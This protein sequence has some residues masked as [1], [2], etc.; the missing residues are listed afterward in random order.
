M[1]LE[2][3]IQTFDIDKLKL[4][5]KDILTSHPLVENQ[6]ALNYRS[7]YEDSCWTDGCGSPYKKDEKSTSI[8]NKSNNMQPRFVDTDFSFINPGL[9]KSEIEKIYLEFQKKFTLGRYRIAVI[10]P[11]TCYGWHFDLEKRIHIPVFTNPGSFIITD[12]GKATHLPSDGG[13][14]MFF[15]NNGYHTAINSSYTE[16]RVHLLINV[17]S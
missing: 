1:Y 10:K 3:L 11:K 12:D 6:I 8:E 16:D 5:V 14:W 7:G 13:C 17:W 9:E 2:K 4:E 15:A